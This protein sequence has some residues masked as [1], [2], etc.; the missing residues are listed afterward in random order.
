MTIVF[1]IILSLLLVINLQIVKDFF[2]PTAIFKLIWLFS[3]FILLLYEDRWGLSLS[4]QTVC[5]FFIGFICFD[6]G[7]LVFFIIC[8]SKK[9]LPKVF[10]Q[11]NLSLKNNRVV[12]LLCITVCIS[13]YLIYD[14]T[15][16]VGGVTGL[17]N[18][19]FLINYRETM[20]NGTGEV[21][22]QRFLFRMLE[23][24]GI[25]TFIFFIRETH[26]TWK[27]KALYSSIIFLV[28]S[29]QLI[30]SGRMRLLAIIVQ[31]VFI[32]LMNGRKF[33]RFTNFKSQQKYLKRIGIV[34][35]IFIAFFYLYGKYAVNKIEDDPLNN[36]AIYTSS[37]LPAFNMT[38]KMNSN[39]S[40]YFG[41]TV[42]GP[43]YNILTQAFGMHFGSNSL[44]ELPQAF[45]HGGNDFSTNVY[46]L[47]NALI[48]DFGVGFVPFGMCLIGFLLAFLKRKSELE[49]V[50]SFWT[51]IYGVFMY[52][53]FISFFKDNFFANSTFTYITIFLF[54]LIFKT[55]IIN[56]SSTK[57]VNS[58]KEKEVNIP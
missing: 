46:T 42:L 7:F 18:Q 13:I 39:T 10:P 45:V 51:A 1:F 53:L 56:S 31:M 23:V 16:L 54:F 36:L 19:D 25:A 21:N 29:V 35:F 38:W 14:I 32:Y 2:H 34:F 15:K 37:G 5:I 41:E 4:L 30:S 3:T 58:S 52:A 9:K 44:L 40:D 12:L 48:V 33:G 22:N 57:I 8:K 11:I 47:Y 6:L 28:I 49:K 43:F 27:R 17:L 20:Y 24:I 50:T 55:R 26:K